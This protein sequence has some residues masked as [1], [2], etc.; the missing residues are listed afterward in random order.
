MAASHGGFAADD[1]ELVKR[2]GRLLAQAP[3]IDTHNEWPRAC[4]VPRHP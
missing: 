4:N 2:A 1:A 3:F